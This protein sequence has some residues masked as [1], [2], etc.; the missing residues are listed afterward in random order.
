MGQQNVF[1]EAEQVIEKLVGQRVDAKQ[2]E[3]LVH[4]YGELLEQKQAVEEKVA[5]D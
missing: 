2:I 4:S 3:R 1:K 5:I